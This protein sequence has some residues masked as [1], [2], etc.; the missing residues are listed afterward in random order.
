MARN[1]TPPAPPP[2]EFPPQEVSDSLVDAA[3]ARY[4]AALDALDTAR[5]LA[6]DA[7]EALAAAELAEDEARRTGNPQTIGVS[8]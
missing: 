7:A 2:E 5:A 6:R 8:E 1:R 4:V 3:R